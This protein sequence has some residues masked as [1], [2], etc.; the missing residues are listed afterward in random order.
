V[1]FTGR[2]TLVTGAVGGIGGATCER[3]AAEGGRLVVTDLDLAACERFAAELPG[4]GHLALPLDVADER[5]WTAVADRLR[6]DGIALHALVNNAGIGS[7]ASVEDEEVE[8]WDRVVRINQTGTWLGMKHLGPLVTGEDP[9]GAIVNMCSMFGT[10]GGFGAS[11]AYHASKGAVRT[12]TKSAAMH[13]AGTGIRVNSIHPGHVATP[14]LLERHGGTDRYRAMLDFSPLGRL[15][16]PAEVAAA[17]AFLASADSTY[18][19]GSELYVDG[20]ATAR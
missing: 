2:T 7:L 8:T 9:G 13:W 6:A 14:G 17:I 15:A 11:A 10:S 20:G 12:L 19:T 1:R 3:I 5:A 16:E 18:M 4:E